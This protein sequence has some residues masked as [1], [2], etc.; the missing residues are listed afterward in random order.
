MSLEDT[1]AEYATMMDLWQTVKAD[2]QG[3][4]LEVRYEDMVE[5]LE[6][7]ARKTLIFS[8]CRGTPRCWALTTHARQKIVRSPTYADVTQPR[9]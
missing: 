5:D 8:A 4:Y 9:L 6:S 1:V 7:V 3:H 2:D